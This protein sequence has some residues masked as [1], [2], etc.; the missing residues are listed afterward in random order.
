[1]QTLTIILTV[2]LLPFTLVRL[3]RWLGWSQQKEYRLD[4]LWHFMTSDEGLQEIGRVLPRREDFTR[5][6]LKRPVITMRAT[7]VGF[8]SLILIGFALTGGYTAGW[9]WLPLVVYLL[10]PVFPAAISLVTEILKNLLSTSLLLAARAKL[11]GRKPRILGITGSYG[12]TTTRHLC[13]HLLS[14][15]FSVFTPPKSHNTPLSIAW[16]ILKN[17]RGEELV[18]LEY[19]AYKKGEIKRL[20]H[21]FQPE[22]SI[23]TGVTEQHLALFGSVENIIKAKG[24]LVKANRLDGVVFYN[25]ADEGAL[26]IC[27]Q[28]SSKKRLDY[29]GQEST[30]ILAN[31]R[32]DAKGRLKFTWQGYEVKTHLVG[33]HYLAAIQGAI[34]V[35][36]HFGLPEAKIRAALTSFLPTDN[37]IQ[38]YQHKQQGFTIINDGRTSNPQGFIAALQVLK[39]FKNTGKNSIL[40]TGGI[41]DLGETSDDI[42]RRLAKAAQPLCDLVLYTGMDGQQVFKEIFKTKLTSHD[43]TIQAVLDKLDEHDVVLV[44]GNT[45]V[46][47]TKQLNRKYD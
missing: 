12:K 1:M 15:Q 17:Y 20:A 36:Q 22:V 9:W 24:E 40:I 2:L 5:T 42:H 38:V 28:D 27:E 11:A 13:A 41:L 10:V 18:F 35:A 37:F 23:V 21:W 14:Q 30:V 32:L 19:A 39:Y 43:G 47:L 4:R 8:L 25:G 33:L 46:W 16:S 3:L 44:E 26:K 7:L 6:G 45:P 34:A 31:A 29:S